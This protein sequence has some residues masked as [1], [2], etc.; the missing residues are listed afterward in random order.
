M[1]DER[2]VAKCA[3]RQALVMLRHVFV[4]V[5]ML[6]CT[7]STVASYSTSD[8]GERSVS[9]A[10]IERLLVQAMSFSSRTCDVIMSLQC[11]VAMSEL[12]VLQGRI[13]IS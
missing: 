2:R 6:R 12:R 10:D 4:P 3:L 9:L 7:W 13:G 5:A 8:N 1:A 11:Y